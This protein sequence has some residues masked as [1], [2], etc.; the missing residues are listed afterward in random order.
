MKLFWSSVLI[1][2]AIAPRLSVAADVAISAL[3]A[4]TTV[5]G[6]DVVPIVQTGT[7]KKASFTVQ[8]GLWDTKY[9]PLDGDLTALAA[10]TGTHNIYYRSAANTWSSVT[11]GSGLSFSGANLTL[12][13]T[14]GL[15][16]AAFTGCSGTQYLGADG[17][18]HTAGS[19]TV[20]NTGGSLTANSVVLG[21]GTNDVK[22]VAGIVTDGSAKLTLGV[23]TTTLGQVKLFGS[24]SGDAT[25][26]PPVVAGTS[27]VVTLPNASSTLPIFSQEITFSG[28]T[29]ART[30]TLP[31]ASFTAARTDAA[32]TFTG[33]QTFSSNPVISAITNTGTVTLFTASDTVVGRA[34]T[35]TLSNK[36]ISPRTHSQSSATSFTPDFD[37]YD[38]EIQTAL[39]GAISIANPTCSSCTEGERRI[40]RLKDNGTARAITWSG[41]QFRAGTSIALPTTTTISK[42][43]YVGFMW[44]NTDTKWDLMA[45]TDG[46]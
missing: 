35:D 17:A 1:A 36:R 16:I 24:T 7:T 34:T 44:N 2:L 30:V 31:D 26:Q 10:L 33:V 32:Q 37:S 45:Y 23:N 6:S 20:T 21:A 29:A 12:S 43:L 9:Q 41:S 22:V 4:A 5:T 3:P 25:I 40:I 11:V 39:A 18:C 38:E 27:T 28:P 13:L 19:G 8:Q 14:S 42:T 46:Y 15:V